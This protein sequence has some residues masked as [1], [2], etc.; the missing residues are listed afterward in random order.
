MTVEQAIAAIHARPRGGERTLCRMEALCRRLGNPERCFPAVHIAGSN[1]KGSTAAMI[2]SALKAGNYRVGLYTSP[3]ITEYRERFQINGEMIQQEAFCRLAGMVLEAAEMLD[4]EGIRCTEFECGTAIAFLW[5][6]EQ[7]CN[8]AVLE[9]GL[10]GKNDAT[11]VIPSPLASVV[12]ALS[13]EHTALLGDTLAQIAAEKAGIIKGNN[14]IVSPGQEPQAIEVLQN[15]CHKTGATLH[16]P[17]ET[18]S[19][20]IRMG[21]EGLSFEYRRQLYSL[22]MTGRHQLRNA[23][24]ALETLQAL[25]LT[26]PLST[27]AIHQGLSKARLPVRFETVEEHPAIVLDGAHN[28]QGAAVLVELLK[29]C[30][31]SPKIGVIGMLADKD[32]THAARILA[33]GFDQVFTVPVD[34]PR[35]CAHPDELAAAIRTVC[36]ANPVS[37]L[38]AA[39][40]DAREFAGDK[41][42]VCC[43]GSLFLSAQARSLL[44]KQK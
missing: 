19:R 33:E 22:C 36:P 25:S 42:L 26:F 40:T 43:A 4:R 5:F 6:R 44:Q 34:N 32:W 8:V 20:L 35:T 17:Q 10:G 7:R 39:L 29:A 30:P 3:Y 2:A 37:S 24:T 31:E 15:W 23:L 1:G 14:A 16:I 27:E 38:A 9:T 13:L 28:P 18:D 41:G 11:N 21:R 12:T